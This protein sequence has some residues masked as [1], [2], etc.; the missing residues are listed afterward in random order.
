MYLVL[1]ASDLNTTH[2][3]CVPYVHSRQEKR[4]TR[5]SEGT[6]CRFKAASSVPSGAELSRAA[7]LF[8]L[9]YERW[10]VVVKA[11]MHDHQVSE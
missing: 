8:P 4:H 2:Y 5:Q 3:D 1:H 7:D 11:L 9:D 10:C 6:G